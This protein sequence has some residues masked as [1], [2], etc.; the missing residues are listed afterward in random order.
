MENLVEDFVTGAS[1]L[2]YGPYGNYAIAL[3]AAVLA[4]QVV[5]G[6]GAYRQLREE[7]EIKG[8]GLCFALNPVGAGAAYL[9]HYLHGD[10]S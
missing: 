7:G 9:C 8:T 4:S 5:Y 3:T 6:I 10:K 1:H 2:Y